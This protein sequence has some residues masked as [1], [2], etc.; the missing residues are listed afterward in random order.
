MSLLRWTDDVTATCFAVTTE[1][2]ISEQ[3]ICRL[4]SDG[5]VIEEGGGRQH[6][7]IATRSGASRANKPIGKGTCTEVDGRYYI[8]NTDV[9]S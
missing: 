7:L 8:R 9:R 4:F 2:A 1:R 5:K 3:D 6:G